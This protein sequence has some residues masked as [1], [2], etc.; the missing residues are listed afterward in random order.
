MKNPLR[1]RAGKLRQRITIQTRAT[2]QNASLSPIGTRTALLSNVPA[3]IRP[4]KAREQLLADGTR[5]DR[6]HEVTVRYNPL[7]TAE[8]EILYGSRRLFIVGVIDVD[9]RGHTHRLMC[10][11]LP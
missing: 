6:T 5:T 10:R 11:E 8:Q 4:L 7:I 9:E 1:I 3:S 2:A